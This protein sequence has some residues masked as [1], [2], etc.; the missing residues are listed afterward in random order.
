MSMVA[1]PGPLADLGLDVFN[2]VVDVQRLQAE[3]TAAITQPQSEEGH[4]PG[5]GR[6]AMAVQP[7]R[8]SCKNYHPHPL[9]IAEANSTSLKRL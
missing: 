4:R 7:P 2:S 8:S 5:T 3:G 9:T 1:V 6:I